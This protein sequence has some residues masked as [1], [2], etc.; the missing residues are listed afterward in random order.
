MKLNLLL[1]VQFDDGNTSDE[2]VEPVTVEEA[3]GWLKVDVPDDDLLIEQLISTA[4][5]QLEHYLNISL[6]R[7]TVTARIQNDIGDFPLPYGPVGEI[8]TITTD[9]ADLTDIAED[10]YTL[11][12]GLFKTLCTPDN[13]KAIV[14]YA[15]GYDVLPAHFKT[16]ILQ[17]CA[18]LYQFRG[19][20]EK[21]DQISPM[22]LLAMKPYRRVI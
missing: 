21:I 17:Q 13:C 7:R 5:Q 1:D 10:N 11:S 16:A 20:V 6:I 14:S 22:V 3:T 12:A 2:L 18:Y 4:R 15:A 8:V 19:D 9:D